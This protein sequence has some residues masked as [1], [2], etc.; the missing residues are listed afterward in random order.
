M[1]VTR[2]LR[3]VNIER[4]EGL[5]RG[6]GGN[7]MSS[8]ISERTARERATGT[9]RGARLVAGLAGAVFAIFGA[10][11]F[12]APRSF[13]DA[14]AVFEPYNAHFVRDIGAFQLGLGAV[15]LLAVMWRDAL[16]VALAGVGVGATFHVVAH[17]IDRD[18]GGAPA[19]DIPVFATIAVALLVASVARARSL[20]SQS[21]QR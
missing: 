21:D 8:S 18:L 12:V 10:W 17:L 11:A 20:S 5:V 14:V 19:T 13:F 15:L 16:L 6:R 2:E 9:D 4:I 1:D 7:V 3:I